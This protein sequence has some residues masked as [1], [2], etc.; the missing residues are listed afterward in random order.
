M[1][2][3]TLDAST[4]ADEAAKIYASDIRGKVVLVTGA[5]PKSLAYE[6]VN[7]I[8]P[9]QPRVVI[10]AGWDQP[11]NDQ[12]VSQFRE[13]A[14]DVEYRTL[15]V[16]F[17]SLASVRAAAKEVNGY[18]FPIDVLV[19]SAGRMATPYALTEDGFE[20]Q[21]GTNYLGPFAFTNLIKQR[22]LAAASPRIVDY[23]PWLAYGQSK[24]AV[25]LFAGGLNERWGGVKSFAVN[26]GSVFG[27]GLGAHIPPQ[28]LINAGF[29]NEDGT[30]SSK[31][32]WKPPHAGAA[33]YVVAAFSPDLEPS[34]GVYLVDCQQKDELARPYA[35]DQDNARRLWAMS[36]EMVGEKFEFV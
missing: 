35:V 30:P 3:P 13:M 23:D 1:S 18:D 32:P 12:A 28:E 21:F 11:G 22:V 5:S 24:T 14:P 20:T 8:V 4:T 2:Q 16:N 15:V 33:V 7:S 34:K 31:F 26:P 27:T 25:L 19:L 17:A 6:M 9:H 36:E 29:L 10:L